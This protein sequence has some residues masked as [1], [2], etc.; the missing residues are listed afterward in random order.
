MRLKALIAD[1]RL[2]ANELQLPIEER[3]E[4]AVAEFDRALCLFEAEA[5]KVFMD[6]EI[7]KGAMTDLQVR[8]SDC[9]GDLNQRIQD[10]SL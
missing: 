3:H 8:V 5:A 10:V 9:I 4:H 1:L 2:K 7:V 6:A